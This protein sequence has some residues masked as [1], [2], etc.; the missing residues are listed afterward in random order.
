M[1]LFGLLFGTFM[2]FALKRAYGRL[3]PRVAASTLRFLFTRVPMLIGWALGAGLA[4]AALLPAA[5]A[6]GVD[7][8]GVVTLVFVSLMS[9]A[10]LPVLVVLP[11]FF[12]LRL[13]KPAPA[14]AL[15]KGEKV[16]SVIAAGHMMRGEL[17]TGK[18]HVT[19]RRLVF[20]PSRFSVQ[21]EP[22]AMRI[23]ALRGVVTEGER[24]VVVQSKSGEDTWLVMTPTGRDLVPRL[25]ALGV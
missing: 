18:L 11:A 3:A 14:L 21:L 24:L 19:D 22:W 12:V 4:L 25:R 15:K 1:V 13:T 20:V 5:M 10:G 17:R 7:A 6:K 8:V 23:E 9:G 2:V 16:V